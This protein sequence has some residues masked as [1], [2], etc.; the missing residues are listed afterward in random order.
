[1][2][3]NWSYTKLIDFEQ[4]PYRVKLKHIDKVPEERAQA[5]ERGTEIHQKAED[6]VRGKLKDFPHELHHFSNEFSRLREDF[7]AGYVS[8]EGEWG[9]D[10]DW[11]PCDYRTAWL[12]IKGDVVLTR[13]GLALVIDH[14]TGQKFGNEIKHGEQVQLYAIATFIR[15][16]NIDEITVE[17]WYLDKDD[18]TTKKYTR[19]EALRYVQPFTKRANKLLSCTDFQPNPNIFSCKWCPFGPNKGNQC[20]YG[21][22]AGENHLQTYR[23]RFG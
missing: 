11:M 19:A 5:A 23:R 20:K 12:R 17:L 9:F 13:P 2:I 18:I 14:K 6:F 4:C 21:V 22:A 3:K 10:K 16:P 15:N 1:M 8:L 7:K